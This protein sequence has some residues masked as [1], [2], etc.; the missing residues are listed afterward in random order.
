MQGV[1]S[2]LA[3]MHMLNMQARNLLRNAVLLTEQCCWH[4]YTIPATSQQ[5]N[6]RI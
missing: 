5:E 2:N 6:D 1:K 3:A 4:G